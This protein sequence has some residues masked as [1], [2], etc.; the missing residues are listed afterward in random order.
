MVIAETRRRAPGVPV[1]LIGSSNGTASAANV[2]ARLAPPAGPDGLVL[3]ATIARPIIQPASGGGGAIPVPG[4]AD[5]RVPTLFV[6]NR[7]DACTPLAGTQPLPLMLTSAPRVEMVLFSS[8]P[9][10]EMNS[11]G[12][13]GAHSFYGIEDQVVASIAEWIGRR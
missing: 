8:P 1:W 11:C 3:T 10:P 7:L 5:I 2:G 12:L 4:L 6:H 9:G 13:Y